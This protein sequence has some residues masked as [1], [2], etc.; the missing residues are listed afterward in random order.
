[1]AGVVAAPR[2]KDPHVGAVPLRGPTNFGETG[3]QL[4]DPPTVVP[5]VS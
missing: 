1:M 3:Y 2:S 4:L 5:R